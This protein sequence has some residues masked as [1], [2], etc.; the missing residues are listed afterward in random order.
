MD[1]LR[2]TRWMERSDEL[3]AFLAHGAVPQPMA[4]GYEAETVAYVLRDKKLVLKVWNKGSNPDVGY[5]YRLLAK[6][7]A[8]GLS[9]PAALGWGYTSGGHQ[10]LATS[11]E[12]LP[13]RRL[14]RSRLSELA[15]LLKRIHTLPY[16]ELEIELP[17][18]DFASYFFPA[19]AEHGDL[20]DA[21]SKLI[22]SAGMKQDCLI[23]GD[24]NMGNVLENAAGGYTLIDWTN[25]QLGDA[26]YDAAWASFLLR[27]YVGEAYG[28]Q[29]LAAYADLDRGD[30]G[31]NAAETFEL[32]ENMA[33][34]RWLL[35]HRSVGLSVAKGE[36]SRLDRFIRKSRY[37][38]NGL[39][40]VTQR[41]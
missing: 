8:H 29:F 18:Y 39:S 28:E 12:G 40:I 33:C 36:I 1:T 2:E 23:H 10:T 7:R 35:L 37:L 25:A 30:G 21:L 9:V 6:L 19:S 24:F 13:V 4:G 22:D 31:A 32:F 15:V 14:E 17:E 20:R 34:L 26:R 5:Q 41:Q 27:I 11:Y 16:R 3:E 38:D